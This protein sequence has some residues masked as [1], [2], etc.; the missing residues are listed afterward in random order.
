MGRDLPIIQFE[1]RPGILDLSWGHPAPNLL[2]VEEWLEAVREATTAYGFQT[3]AYGADPGPGPLREWIASRLSEVDAASEPT[4]IF[5][6]GGAS[7]ALALTTAVLAEPGD[8]AIV[9]SPTYHL[10]FPTLR[11]HGVELVGAPADDDGI[12]VDALSA[13]IESLRRQGRRVPMLYVVPT[14]GN[15]TGRS[16]PDNRRRAL[17]DLALR[18]GITIVEDDTYREL[19][20]DGVAPTSLWG[21][22]STAIGRAHPSTVEPVIR[23]GS[24]AKS[25]AA[26]LR[27]GWIQAS[28][29]YVARV[30]RLGY[31]HSG[32]GVNHAAAVAMAAFGMSDRY[33]RHLSTIR[34]QYALRRDALV[35]A[36]GAELADIPRPAGGWFVWLRLP[37]GVRANSLLAIAERHGVS[38]LPGTEFYVDGRSGA[39]RVRLSFSMLTPDDLTEAGSRLVSAI[40]LAERTA[41][42]AS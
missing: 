42:G 24:F 1:D 13:V 5:V 12:D 22:A 2:P 10:A 25:V 7:H 26:G 9:D 39:D 23:L 3:L 18:S 6:T 17:V 28:P 4:E 40:R 30:A 8:V 19:V 20:Y 33:T 21:T 41:S 38:F 37:S 34:E 35:N 27:L 29:A 16:L 32:G 11:D 14:F 31:V 36:L 15:P